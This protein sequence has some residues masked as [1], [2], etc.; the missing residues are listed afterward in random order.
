MDPNCTTSQEITSYDSQTSENVILDSQA[1]EPLQ[2]LTAIVLPPNYLPTKSQ[3]KKSST[4]QN[5]DTNDSTSYKPGG[6]LNHKY[7][8]HV[9]P[10]DLNQNV[11]K[12]SL[13]Y[14]TLLDGYYENGV[15]DNN[16]Y[17]HG[18]KEHF[19]SIIFIT[20]SNMIG[21]S[22]TIS[23]IFLK[24]QHVIFNYDAIVEWSIS[25]LPTKSNVNP[26]Y[27]TIE[28]APNTHI[29]GNIVDNIVDATSF[30]K[31]EYGFTLRARLRGGNSSRISWQWTQ[32]FRCSIK[33]THGL[34]LDEDCGLDVKVELVP[35]IICD[36]LPEVKYDFALNDR[37]TSDFIIYLEINEVNE[38]EDNSTQQMLKFYVHSSTL[39]ARSDYFRALMDSHMI[40]SNERSLVLTDI[41]QNSLEILLILASYL[42]SQYM[43]SG[44]NYF[45]MPQGS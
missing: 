33:D 34:S 7:P 32:L 23:T 13:L 28:F 42:I 8:L 37:I 2:S 10:D 5:Q 43:I 44:L 41:T 3:E 11:Y 27:Q 35:D 9:L 39:T 15:I 24:L 1:N 12:H 38:S 22:I 29:V 16:T 17:Q 20:R 19:D 30:V 14:N 40:E 6:L 26:I 31:G 45:M 18:M 4:T 21:K 36:P 25:S